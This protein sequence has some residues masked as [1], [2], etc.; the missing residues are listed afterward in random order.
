LEQVSSEGA[1][2]RAAERGTYQFT[3]PNPYLGRS[4]ALELGQDLFRRGVLS[5]AGLA[6][7]AA[8]RADPGLCEGQG[9]TLVHFSVQPEPFLT[10]NTP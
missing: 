10:Q 5:E 6:L 7:E 9:L 4:D 2:L 8:V 3:D 1:A